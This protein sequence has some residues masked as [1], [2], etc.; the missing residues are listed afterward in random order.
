MSRRNKTNKP[1]Y[2]DR[3]QRIVVQQ[4]VIPAGPRILASLFPVRVLV[5]WLKEP[6]DVGYLGGEHRLRLTPEEFDRYRQLIR[7]GKRARFALPSLIQ[8][9]IVSELA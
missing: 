8:E 3:Q 2:F 7:N 4:I 9:D 6:D 5:G 1:I